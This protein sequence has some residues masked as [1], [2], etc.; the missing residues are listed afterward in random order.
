MTVEIDARRQEHA[1]CSDPECDICLARRRA[2]N[3]HQRMVQ[4]RDGQWGE[5]T[6]G[7]VT[8]DVPLFLLMHRP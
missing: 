1:D 2:A 5:F 7:D 6:P 8:A 3:P 4:Y